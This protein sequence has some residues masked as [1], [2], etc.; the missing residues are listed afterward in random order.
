MKPLLAALAVLCAISADA[1]TTRKR[2][3][4]PASKPAPA[5]E[6]P[7]PI[8]EVRVEG[9]RI[10]A[11]EPILA[12][13]ALQPGQPGDQPLFEA[14]RDRLIA[15]GAFA[16]VGF[17]YEPASNGRGYLVTFE[18]AEIEQIYPFRFD[19]LPLAD[20]AL[21]EF[22]R[23]A[24]PL[25]TDKI[26]GSR[27]L[28]DRWARRIEEFLAQSNHAEKVIARLSADRPDELYVLFHPAAAPP[29]VAEVRFRNHQVIP[30]TVLQ[31]A[32]AGVAIGST[33]T[34]ARFRQLLETSIRPLYEARGRIGVAFPKVETERATD[35]KGLV[36]TVH[37]EEGPG[38]D[39]GDV[40]VDGTQ[41]LDRELGR[42]TN[43][44]SGDVASFEK[45]AAALDRIRER[46]RAGGYMGVSISVERRLDQAKRKVDLLIHVLP[47]SQY[48]FGKLAI[49][50]LD[51]HAEAAV[52]KMWGLDAGKPFNSGYPDH[53]L[54]RIREEGIFENLGKTA[55]RIQVNDRDLT[56][57]VTLV[58]R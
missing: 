17:R 41:T 32:I 38:Y 4:V 12:A 52:K 42:L 5:P 33:Y 48:T 34:E 50:G 47:G 20:A 31:N 54:A 13:T 49:E 57:D 22:L 6:A 14:A 21:R 24:E 29:V 23:R 53:F 2:R 30:A 3:P 25:F 51:I 44:Q 55:S 36:V 43:L 19:N 27:P 35:V 11:L 39:F 9:H 15:T 37:V 56:V 7:W 58:F 1:Q 8:E 28:L 45:V 46:L 10:Y 16:S 40:V 18:V 26:P